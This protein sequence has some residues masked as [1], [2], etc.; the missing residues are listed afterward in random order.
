MT[1]SVSYNPDDHS[2]PYKWKFAEC[3][4]SS[5][6]TDDPGGFVGFVSRGAEKIHAN[7]FEWFN[8]VVL[9]SYGAKRQHDAPGRLAVG[10]ET[11]MFSDQTCATTGMQVESG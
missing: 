4:D 1:I 11:R 9:C 6:K 7:F 10:H 5:D 3:T 8:P 2:T